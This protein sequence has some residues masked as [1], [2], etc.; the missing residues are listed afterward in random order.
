[1]KSNPIYIVFL[2]FIIFYSCKKDAVPEPTDYP[3]VILSEVNNITSDGA[4]FNANITN[5]GNQKI[6]DYG[7]AWNDST[8]K[9]TIN[10]I[11][12]SL[13]NNPS[14]GKFSY[15]VNSDLEKGKTFN[16]RAYIKTDKFIVYSNISSFISEGCLPPVITKFYP[17]SG[18]AGRIITIIGKN[19]SS[20]LNNNKVYF[21]TNLANVV[22]ANSDTLLVQSP[23]TSQSLSVK[24]E[25]EVAKQKITTSSYF[26]LIYP[27]L[28]T[29]DFIGGKRFA[30]SYCVLNNYGYT[31]LG[32]MQWGST[33]LAKNF[34]QFSFDTQQWSQR[35]D[36]PASE[37]EYATSFSANGNVYFGLGVYLEGITKR[38]NDL[39]SFNPKTNEWTQKANYPGGQEYWMSNFVINDTVYL[40]SYEGNEF[41][42]YFPLIDSWQKQNTMAQIQQLAFCISYKNKGYLVG[43]NGDIWQYNPISKNFIKYGEITNVYNL[44]EGFCIDGIIYVRGSDNFKSFDINTKYQYTISCP[45]NTFSDIVFAFQHKAYISPVYSTDFWEFYPR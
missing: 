27:W 2:L 20:R 4:T 7:F 15:K 37:R 14:L 10:S 38:Y 31:T 33:Y 39:W 32:E 28:K 23:N 19:F 45:C 11:I 18:S 16:V 35:K 17:D 36:F 41:W 5:L 1:M 9:P 44:M 12:K 13:G 8:A 25:L 22:K 29:T 3:F 26:K 43:R 30:S 40:Y 24:I 42:I 6:L 34:W 21:G